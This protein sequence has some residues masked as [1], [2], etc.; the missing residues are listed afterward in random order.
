MTGASNNATPNILGFDYQKFIALERCLSGKDN[1]VIWI[2]YF[3]DVAHNGTSTEVKHHITETFLND[4][5]RDFWKTLYNLMSDE[6][7]YFNFTRFELL[8][9]SKIKEGSAF[10]QWNDLPVK[11]KLERLRK[12]H[13]TKTIEKYHKEFIS[14]SDDE[15]SPLI[16]KL[17]IIS[18]QPNIKD[19]LEKI[20]LHE[21]LFLIPDVHKETFIE[22]ML[23]FISLKA[24]QNTDMWHIEYNEFKREM[25]GFSMPYV[26]KDYPFPVISKREVVREDSDNYYFV[27][28]LKSIKIEDSMITDAIIDYL[29]SEKSLLKLIKL[30]STLAESLDDFEDDLLQDLGLLKL[31]HE[32]DLQTTGAGIDGEKQSKKM[33]ADCLLMQIK[34]IRNV[35]SMEKYYQKGR[36]HSHVE[37]QNFSWLFEVIENETK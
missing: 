9:T 35:H 16:E 12:I 5:H 8:T 25:I 23:G 2:E 33:Y 4:T 13:P 29:R 31:K 28:E 21:S 37:Q 11:T 36:I 3:G 24:I 17:E 18:S 14:R 1:D 32:N 22:K 7:I 20:K 15:I 19:K 30:H 26:Q 34:Q 6:S 10:F 27:N